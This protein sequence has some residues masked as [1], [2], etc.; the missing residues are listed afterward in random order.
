[1]A[2]HVALQLRLLPS[3]P[4]AEVTFLS[5]GTDGQ[6]GPTD[7][8]GAVVSGALLADANIAEAA[9]DALRRC[10]SHGFFSTHAPAAL[11]RP[12]LTGTNVM[13]IQVVLVEPATPRP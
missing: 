4:A 12:G 6:D 3:L 1:M 2:L 13:D 9:L 7:A 8:A 10:D 5:G 11:L